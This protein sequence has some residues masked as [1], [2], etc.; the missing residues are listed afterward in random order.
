MP[1]ASILDLARTMLRHAGLRRPRPRAARRS[2]KRSSTAEHARRRRLVM[3][4]VELILASL[5]RPTM[6]V[7]RGPPVGRRPEPRDHRRARPRDPATGRCCSCG[8]Y[9]TDEAPPGTS[10]ARLAVAAGDPADRRGAPARAA[11]PRPRPP[12]SRRSS[13]TP[14]C[15]RR[16]RSSAAVY[17]RT[18][19]IPLH[20][21]ELLGAMSAEARADGRAIREATRPGHDRGRR[22]RAA[23]ATGRPR[24]RPRPGRR[25]HRPLLRAR[26]P[27]RD[28]GRAARGARRAAPGARSTTSS[29]IRPAV[30][31]LVD[32]RHQLLRDAIY[33]TSRSRDRRRFHARA[34]EFG[35]QLEGAVGDPRLA[36]LRAGRPAPPGV[37]DGPRGSP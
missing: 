27:G 35:A 28:H 5:A 23:R 37:R 14:G 30:R 12:S 34:G 9:R 3:D 29:S 16:A 10:L 25:G 20:I 19:G 36:P 7:V 15:R 2:A 33:R 22:P 32:F 11:R 26:R 8:D 31:G 24:R 17:E 4:V 13:S 6:L 18:D 1:A 21:E